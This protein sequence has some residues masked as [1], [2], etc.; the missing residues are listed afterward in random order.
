[1]KQILPSKQTPPSHSQQ[2]HYTNAKMAF[3]SVSC[4]QLP[5]RNALYFKNMYPRPQ[6][7]TG[8]AKRQRGQTPST[9]NKQLS[10]PPAAR[11]PATHPTASDLFALRTVPLHQWTTSTRHSIAQTFSNPPV[12]QRKA[13]IFANDSSHISRK[14][15]SG[16]KGNHRNKAAIHL[17]KVQEVNILFVKN[18]ILDDL[19]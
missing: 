4:S 17:I 19:N 10:V 16:C 3:Q 12:M 15:L 6:R 7:Q 2:H 9:P 8:P 1:M 11:C 14:H 5:H 13:L 18:V